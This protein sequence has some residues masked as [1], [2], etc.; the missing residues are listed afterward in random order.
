M[1]HSLNHVG[2]AAVILAL[3]FSSTA[4][5]RGMMRCDKQLIEQNTKA[6]ELLAA[7][8]QPNLK[9]SF[10]VQVAN[11]NYVAGT[12]VWTYDFG[13]EQ[14]IR[15][16]TVR[17]G[18]VSDID[19][20]G[21]GFAAGSGVDARCE[22]GELLVGQSKYRLVAQCGEPAAKHA[23]SALKPL[24]ARPEIY[25]SS[26]DAYAYRNQYSTPVYR[27]E[28]IYHFGSHDG[29]RR[30]ILEDGRVSHVETIDATAER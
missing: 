21:Y 10:L 8:G 30:V 5:A 6:T 2:R 14:L 28:W 13:P 9:D 16:V 1:F 17:D 15:L 18:R 3:L 27:E 24:F 12:E 26:A 11:G 25:R 19:T 23:E 22:A 29:S 20:D 4:S 7:C